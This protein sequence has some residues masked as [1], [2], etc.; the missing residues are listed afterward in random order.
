MSMSRAVKYHRKFGLVQIW[1]HMWARSEELEDVENLNG[2]R[3]ENWSTYRSSHRANDLRALS[4]PTIMW[5]YNLRLKH[6]ALPTLLSS[7]S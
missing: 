5:P 6:A 2:L 7:W 4:D 3:D 1:K